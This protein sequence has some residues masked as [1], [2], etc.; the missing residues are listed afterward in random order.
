MLRVEGRLLLVDPVPSFCE[1]LAVAMSRA[2]QEVVGWATDEREAAD[3][4]DHLE[5]DLVLT[6][7]DLD[8]G[9]GLA[10]A[11]RLREHVPVI[12]LTRADAGEVLMDAVAAGAVGCLGHGLAV[13]ELI[14]CLHDP[15]ATFVHHDRALLAMLR[16]AGA[17]RFEPAAARLMLLT[18]REREVLRHLAD[19]HDDRAIA[20][21]LSLSP[22]TVRTHVGHILRKLEVHSRAEATRRWLSL[23]AAQ[24]EGP[25]NITRITGPELHPR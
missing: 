15:D 6:E 2:G 25:D 19:G 21:R 12:V 24:G 18:A 4:V 10:L 5:P 7:L 9:S 1:S 11:R 17:E 8:R 14:A 13:S 16:R 3:L 20:V 23:K 22:N